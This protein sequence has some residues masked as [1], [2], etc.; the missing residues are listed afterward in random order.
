MDSIN[1]IL[2]ASKQP[3][4]SLMLG[5]IQ[6]QQT[7]TRSNISVEI[8]SIIPLDEQHTEVFVPIFLQIGII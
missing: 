2:R 1:A 6:Q 8:K 4:G 3:A 5:S 7:Q